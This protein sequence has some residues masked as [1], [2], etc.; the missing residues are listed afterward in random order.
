MLIPRPLEQ[1]AMLFHEP[2]DPIQIASGQTIIIRQSHHRPQ[3]ELRFVPARTHVDVNRF[4]RVT[5]VGVEEE[6]KPLDT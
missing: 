5:L 4:T 6:P 2:L 1:V 3:P